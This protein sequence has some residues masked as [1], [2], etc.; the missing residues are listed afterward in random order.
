LGICTPNPLYV[1]EK[2]I[3]KNSIILGPRDQLAR[4]EFSISGINWISGFAS[5]TT[6]QCFV[7]T[8]YRSKETP[9]FVK[10]LPTGEVQVKLEDPIPDITP[11]QAAVLY[12]GDTC[13]GGG[14]IQI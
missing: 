12:D 7:Q 6:F 2:N 5:S 11:G 8:R 3:S 13:L 14:I 4:T 10:L 1:I 9:C